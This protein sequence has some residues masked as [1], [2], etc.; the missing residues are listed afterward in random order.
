[1]DINMANELSKCCL[2]HFTQAIK[3]KVEN[4]HSIHHYYPQ[5]TL[6]IYLGITLQSN[7][8]YDRYVQDITT[9]PAWSHYRITTNKC[10]NHI[11]STERTCI[12]GYSPTPAR[13]CLYCMVPFQRYLV[14]AIEKVQCRSACYIYNDYHS[15]SSVPTMIKHMLHWDSLDNNFQN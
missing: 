4:T 7:L 2:I 11:T 8:R 10:Q 6:S 5:I 14:D 3:H 9:K 15:D 13:I 1:M 12:Q